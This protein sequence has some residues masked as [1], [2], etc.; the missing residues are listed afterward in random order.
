[1]VTH[2]RF[3]AAPEKVTVSGWSDN[4]ATANIVMLATLCSNP[5]PIKA[6]RHQKIRMHFA[7]SFVV[8]A[9]VQIARQTSQLHNIA[10]A[11][12]SLA[13]SVIFLLATT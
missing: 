4:K 10:R 3:H 7:V 13:G 2:S 1:M 12:N 11:T 8:R 6:N 5:A 9:E